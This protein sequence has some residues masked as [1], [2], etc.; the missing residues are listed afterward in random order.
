MLAD[1]IAAGRFPAR[2]GDHAWHWGNFEHCAWCEFDTICP[3]DR[4]EEWE[5]VRHEPSLG[6]LRR[7]AEDGSAS[8]LET[9]V[10]V[11]R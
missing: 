2:P 3:R 5:R 6:P 1:G 4:D 7:L 10:E 11:A 9:P 8:V